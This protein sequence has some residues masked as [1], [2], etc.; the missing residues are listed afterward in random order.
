MNKKFNRKIF[1][2]RKN[3]FYSIF[4]TFF[5]LIFVYYIYINLYKLENFTIT[6]IQKY[7]QKFNY[8]L[9]S[10]EIA[11]LKYIDEKHIIKKIKP[12]LNNSIFLIPL[13]NLSNSILEN[14]WVK[15]VSI[16]IDY[17]NKIYIQITE[18]DPIGIYYYNEANYYFNLKGKIIDY[19]KNNNKEL[20]V[21]SGQS[22]V[23]EAH[24]LLSTMSKVEENFQYKVLQARFVGNRRWNLLLKN[25]LLIKLSEKN[26][27]QSIENY[28][29]LS[30]N[31]SNNDLKDI[32]TVDLRDF[33]KG[34]IEY[35]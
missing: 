11:G 10:Y 21:F 4:F 34:I 8:I 14:N 28:L 19:V 31:F 2:I 3:F 12:Y 6:S 35:K 26:L 15:N 32:K 23:L 30:N 22:S 5:I 27:Q 13:E 33:K 1:L 29:K 16:K 20:I 24:S 18:Y 9:N 17:K 7:S 25:G